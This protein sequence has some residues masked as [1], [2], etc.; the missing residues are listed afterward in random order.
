MPYKNETSTFPL[1]GS[2]INSR[3]R[4]ARRQAGG[5][6]DLL[7]FISGGEETLMDDAPVCKNEVGGPLDTRM[8][9]A[10]T[11]LTLFLRR[12]MASTKKMQ[13]ALRDMYQ[14][15]H[16]FRESCHNRDNPKGILSLRTRTKLAQGRPST[17]PGGDLLGLISGGEETLMDDAGRKDRWRW[18]TGHVDAVH[19]KRN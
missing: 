13:V 5:G 10:E 17:G 1:P 16:S 11:Q 4:G 7:G 9:Q 19:T 6:G 2:K 15:M 12:R 14:E 18:S 8:Q 3:H